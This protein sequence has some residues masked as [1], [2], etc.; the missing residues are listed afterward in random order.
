MTNVTSQSDVPQ[1]GTEYREN[2]YFVNPFEHQ[3]IWAS[4]LAHDSAR[5]E[6]LD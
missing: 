2:M 6:D 1:W 4:L 5:A 3:F